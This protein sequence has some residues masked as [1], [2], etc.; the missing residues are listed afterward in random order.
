MT[1]TH[2]FR[3]SK[4]LHY[5]QCCY[6]LTYHST[7]APEPE[8]IYTDDYWS[9]SHDHST[10]LDQ[11][12]NVD[13]HQENGVSKYQF[14][15]DRIELSVPTDGEFRGSAIELGCAP[16]RFLQ[17]LKGI[18][19]FSRVV[20]VEACQ[21]FEADI[22]QIGCFGGE[23]VFGFFPEATKHLEAGSFQYVVAMD[24]LEHSHEPMA[25]LLECARLLERR[26][27]L[28]LILPMVDGENEPEERFFHPIEHC[29][30]YSQIHASEM[31]REGGFEDV[32][33]DAWTTGH[34]SISARK[35]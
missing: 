3:P 23:L 35:A 7:I 8:T 24:L 33:Y 29:F 5:E 22:R 2:L 21:A 30:I 16:G 31:L 32:K 14:A 20:G 28:F 19:R 26:G 9:A 10:L 11:I 27:Q 12:H 15:L 1:C 18:G 34:E 6:C 13:V 17:H 4:H 25:F